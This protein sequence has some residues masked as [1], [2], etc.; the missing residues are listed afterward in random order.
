MTHLK[1]GKAIPVSSRLSSLC[2]ELDASTGL[3]RVGGRLRRCSELEPDAVHPIILDPKHPLSKLIIKDYDEHL[4]HP[5]TERVFAEVQRKY[6]VLRGREAVR[7]HQFKCTECRRWRARPEPP[8][9]ADLPAARQRVFKPAFYSSGADCFGPYTIKIGRRNEKR[10]GSLFKCMTTR[11]VYIDL[12]CSL[13]SDSFLMALRR[14]ISR[15][16]RPHEILC[17]QGTNLRGG[18]RELQESFRALQS[19]LQEHLASQRIRFLFNPPG[20]PHFGGCWE[21]EIQ[22]VKKALRVTIGAQTVT[23]EVLWTILIEIEGILNSKPLGY[24]SADA[25][26]PDPITPFCFLIGRRDASLPQMVYQDSEQLSRRRWRH[27]QLL[28]DYFW[29]HFI[30]YYLPGFQAR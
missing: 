2:P 21:R 7:R 9:M 17:D 22:S 19:E 16:G 11:A 14:F 20:A 12:L 27:S 15:R 1:A 6:W 30:K 4:L 24:A 26:D 23:E 25:A 13:D 8:Q 29:N 28:A 18:D 3:L 5:G 10:W